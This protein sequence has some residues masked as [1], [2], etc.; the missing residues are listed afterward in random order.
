MKTRYS[1][2]EI[3]CVNL[4]PCEKYLQNNGGTYDLMERYN[5]FYELMVDYFDLDLVDQYSQIAPVYYSYSPYYTNATDL[6]HPNA[7][8]H[9]R[10]AQLI[11]KAMGKKNGII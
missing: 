3:Y 11:L 2:A 10:F 5:Y 4:M 8:G 9:T 6:L 1:N 7:G